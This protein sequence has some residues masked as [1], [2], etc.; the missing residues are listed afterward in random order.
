MMKLDK[1]IVMPLLQAALVGCD[2][3]EQDAVQAITD[4]LRPFADQYDE[5]DLA[6]ATI[7]QNQKRDSESTKVLQALVARRPHHW[8]AKSLLAS[9]YFRAGKKEW[10][11]LVN[12]V[13]QHSR[14]AG[15][16]HLAK[17]VL[18]E[19]K[20]EVA[21]ND[22]EQTFSGDRHGSHVRNRRTG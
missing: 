14:D 5:I 6:M 19:A 18:Q 17:L 1:Q 13:L 9:R 4:S 20:G 10:R 2:H 11:A 8:C 12:E 21:P 22:G 3:L 16:L 15:A 7:L